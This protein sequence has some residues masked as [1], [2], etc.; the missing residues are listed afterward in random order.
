MVRAGSDCPDTRGETRHG[1]GSSSGGRGPVAQLP[2]VVRTDALCGAGLD[3]A[4]EVRPRRD[5][6]R[7]EFDRRTRRCTQICGDNRSTYGHRDDAGEGRDEKEAGDTHWNNVPST[8][9]S[10]Q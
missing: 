5:D 9:T 3:P 6:R 8:R 2:P 1:D 10:G 7:G 4:V